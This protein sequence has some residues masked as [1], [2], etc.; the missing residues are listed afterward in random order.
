MKKE[1]RLADFIMGVLFM[2]L[3][4]LWIFQANQMMKVDV[5][6]GPGDYPKVIAVGLFIVGFLQAVMNIRV[7]RELSSLNIKLDRKRLQR[8]CIFVA[9]TI[10]YIRL[11]DYLGFLLL[12]PFYIFFGCWF[13]GYRKYVTSIIVSIAVTGFCYLIFRVLFQVI[14]PMFRLF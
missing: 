1:T 9:V 5:G 12:T 3:S 4:V 11:L 13:F 6:I 8:L 7:L 2:S 14:L 10:V